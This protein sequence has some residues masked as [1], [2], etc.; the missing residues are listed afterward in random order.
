MLRRERAGAGEGPGIARDG[1][2]QQPAGDRR[3]QA[4]QHALRQTRNPVR[5][6][7]VGGVLPGQPAD[8]ARARRAEVLA[9]R[10]VQPRDMDL[11][12][13]VGRRVAQIELQP[14]PSEHALRRAGVLDRP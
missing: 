10:D 9:Q 4:A 11:V 3:R 14:G 6:Q 13:H 12:D 2:G 8:L 7:I 1:L 5:Q